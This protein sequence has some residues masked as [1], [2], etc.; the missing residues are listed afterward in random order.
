MKGMLWPL[1]GGIR[2]GVPIIK[3][4]KD[5]VKRECNLEINGKIYLIGMA[6]FFFRTNPY[7]SG[8]GVDDLAEVFYGIGT[9]QIKLDWLHNNPLIVTRE[10]YRDIE[11]RLHP[12]VRD[13]LY[14]IFSKYWWETS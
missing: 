9:G 10:N 1:G 2:R 7:G 13:N 14:V 11:K 3:S 4:L 8:N 6:R 12:Y 5:L